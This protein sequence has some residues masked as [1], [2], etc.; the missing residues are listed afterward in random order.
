MSSEFRG[1]N[2]CLGYENREDFIQTGMSPGP[3][4][5]NIRYGVWEDPHGQKKGGTENGI[6]S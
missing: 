4:I 1:G 3:G 2:S 6:N 5:M